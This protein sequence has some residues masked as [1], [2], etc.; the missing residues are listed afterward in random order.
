MLKV[1]SLNVNAVDNKGC[2]PLHE[3]VNLGV[4]DIVNVLLQAP[5]IDINLSDINGS[6]PLDVARLR[7]YHYI[8]K[9]LE[10][11]AVIESASMIADDRALS[12][13]AGAAR[14]PAL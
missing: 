9:L 2:T 11:R 13:E 10:G 4:G 1:D 8:V 7:N 5:G 6:K 3:A 12:E 14:S